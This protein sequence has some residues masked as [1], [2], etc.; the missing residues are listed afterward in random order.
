[1]APALLGQGAQS[2][3]GAR[4]GVHQRGSWPWRCGLHTLAAPCSH[5]SLT[6]ASAPHPTTPRR[7]RRAH[8]QQTCRIMRRPMCG[9]RSSALSA[10][11]FG[12]TTST[13]CWAR[14]TRLSPSAWMMW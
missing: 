3:T 5:H 8:T 12:H 10:T 13:R 6:H 11:T 1:M 9:S 14:P 7:Q 4:V 2:P